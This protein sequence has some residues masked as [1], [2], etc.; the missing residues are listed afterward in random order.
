MRGDI[1]LMLQKGGASWYFRSLAS[2]FSY[3]V[4]YVTQTVEQNGNTVKTTAV[5]RIKTEVDTF[6]VGEPAHWH[7]TAAG[8]NVYRFFKWQGKE[9]VASIK[10][11]NGKQTVA[12]TYLEGNKKLTESLLD[13]IRTTAVY[14][15]VS[16]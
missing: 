12:R 4:G 9:L 3:G 7:E 11:G 16:P 14:T 10:L 2:K 1:D 15:R 5:T 13:G 8:E 6:T